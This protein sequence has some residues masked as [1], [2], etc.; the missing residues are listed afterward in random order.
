MAAGHPIAILILLL[1]LHLPLLAAANLVLEDGYTVTTFSDLNPL[2]ASGPHPYAVLPRPRTGDLLLLDSAGAAL[3]TLA[4]SASP[5][6]PR[7]LAGGKRGD[8]SADAAFYRPRGVAV[9]GADNVYVVD[10]VPVDDGVHGVV[11]KVAPDG[12]RANL[13]RFRSPI[14]R[15]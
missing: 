10:R 6:E 9:D 14:L 8:A 4:L 7:R 5:G 1:H 15:C 11:R 3:Y 12:E 13:V 2:P